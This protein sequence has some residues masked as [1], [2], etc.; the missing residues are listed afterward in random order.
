SALFGPYHRKS[1]FL[2]N[3]RG[4]AGQALPAE[5]EPAPPLTPKDIERLEQRVQVLAD[6]LQLPVQRR[7]PADTLLGEALETAANVL[8]A[9]RVTLLTQT[10]DRKELEVRLVLGEDAPNIKSQFRV[11]IGH[12]ADVFSTAL[13][14]GK[15][16]VIGDALG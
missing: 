13:R 2:F 10:G 14:N 16:V 3:A 7:P 8:D 11:P 1:R 12:G 6:R 4:M 15:N 5:L 9:P